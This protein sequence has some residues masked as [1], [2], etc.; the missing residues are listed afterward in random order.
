MEKNHSLKLNVHQI[1]GVG[2]T[3]MLIKSTD[4]V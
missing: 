3:A 4:F 2:D 1:D